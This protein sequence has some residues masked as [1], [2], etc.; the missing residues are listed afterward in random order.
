MGQYTLWYACG[1][2]WNKQK[3]KVVYAILIAIILVLNASPA[4]KCQHKFQTWESFL[5]L[6]I[7]YYIYLYDFYMGEINAIVMHS[8]MF[9]VHEGPW[10]ASPKKG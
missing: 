10:H 5:N 3:L 7:T 6:N 1:F 8:S 9:W 2:Y 4:N